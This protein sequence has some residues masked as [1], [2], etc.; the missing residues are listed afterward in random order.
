MWCSPPSTLASLKTDRRPKHS[1]RADLT[2]LLAV[3]RSESYANLLYAK[4]V[5][6]TIKARTLAAFAIVNQKMWSCSVP[7]AAFHDP[8]EQRQ[9]ERALA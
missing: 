6:A 5:H 1:D 9:A 2:R 4:V 8:D 7:G 3:R